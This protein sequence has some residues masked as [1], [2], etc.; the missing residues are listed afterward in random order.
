MWFE[1]LALKGRR[2]CEVARLPD[3][4]F[5][6]ALATNPPLRLWS[7]ALTVNHLTTNIQ[8][9]L[10]VARKLVF[11]L[12]QSNSIRA[13][14]PQAPMK[15]AVYLIQAFLMIGIAGA[16]DA[17]TEAQQILGSAIGWWHMVDTKNA[18][19]LGGALKIHAPVTLGVE[20]VGLEQADSLARAG[21]GKVARLDGGWIEVGDGDGDQ[22]NPG[23]DKFTGLI[24]LRCPAASLWDTRGFFTKG[25]GHNRLVFNFFSHDFDNEEM[26]LGCEIGLEGKAG[27]GGQVTAPIAQIGATNWHDVIARYDGHELVLFI[28]GVPLDRRPASGQLRQGNTRPLAIGAGGPGEN[29]F[30]GLVDHAALWDRALTDDEI[31]ILCGGPAAVAAKQAEFAK[32]EPPPRKPPTREL[33]ERAR[34]LV[35]K[36][37]NDPHRPRYHLLHPEEGLIMPG[38]PNGAIWWKGRYHLF[39]IFQRYQEAKPRTVHCWGH[40]SSLDLVHWEHHPT[41]LDVSPGDPDHRIFSGNAFVTREGVPLIL[42]HG[43]DAGNCIARAEDDGLIKWRKAPGNPIVRIPKR[44]DPAYGKYD[45]WDPHG[46]LEGDTYYAIFGGNPGTG[47]KPS[48]FKG[49]DM[50][51]LSYQSPFMPQDH[52]SQPG[53]DVS[54]PDF[55]RLGNKHVLVCI[56]HLRGARYFIGR[57]EQENFVPETHARMN[58]PG[59]Q[60]FAP[61]T[62]LDPEGRRILWAWCLD[63]RPARAQ[64]ASGWSGVMSLPRVLSL[65]KDNQLRIE[66]VKEL[67]QLRYNPRSVA[68]RLLAGDT[69]TL[70]PNIS[71]DGLEIQANFRLD[72]ATEVGLNLRRAP[73]G[74]EETGVFYAPAAGVLRIDLSK[75]TLDPAIHY[76]S[77][78]ITHPL[79]P[80]DL[81]R[82]VFQQE[83]PCR[84][85]RGESLHLR[86][87]LDR[88]MLEVF[89]NGRLCVTQRLWPTR[90][91]AVGVSLVCRGGPAK[92]ESLQAWDMA[93]TQ[94][95]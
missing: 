65:G 6:C 76:R 51:R 15:T 85:K 35:G 49:P 32:Y 7:G 90:R 19:G 74:A 48:L 26:R 38:D 81:N 40:V 18:T 87:F 86:V 8:R 60:F 9:K 92:L 22:F 59:G 39:Y 67:E 46:W 62:L 10:R 36:F 30:P 53:E 20:L 1:Q 66:P 55:F 11:G 71:G 61:E 82:R 24:R 64:T 25:G 73:D 80:E 27:L 63:E 31:V 83:A 14:Y 4:I 2:R 69:E 68:A 50:T 89:V 95:D 3:L 17:A 56:S 78:C 70:L 16:A 5:R 57:W 12:K 79:D 47:A 43:V 72:G 29:A 33:V 13:T 94:L 28:D 21:E 37:Q 42:Y 58:W 44:G 34:E 41:A 54:C 52:W 93:A 91:D 45:S 23:G 88:S 77:W 84:L 75:S